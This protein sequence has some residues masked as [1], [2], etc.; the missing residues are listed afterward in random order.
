MRTHRR[1]SGPEEEKDVKDKEGMEE[2]Q[3]LLKRLDDGS[4][5]EAKARQTRGGV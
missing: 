3:L 1:N 5:E 4:Q 2:G